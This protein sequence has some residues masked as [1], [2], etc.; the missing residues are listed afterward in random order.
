MTPYLKYLLPLALLLSACNT[1]SSPANTTGNA[2]Q[3]SLITQVITPI[4]ASTL[5]DQ[6]IV[7]Q[8][9]RNLGID[10]TAV[11][12]CGVRRVESKIAANPGRLVTV[13][14]STDAQIQLISELGTECTQELLVRALGGQPNTGATPFPTRTPEPIPT[15]PLR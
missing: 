6:D 7:P 2:S 10:E 11:C 5:R 14:S 9:A 8:Q 13:L 1:G 3:A 4:C 15:A 12:E